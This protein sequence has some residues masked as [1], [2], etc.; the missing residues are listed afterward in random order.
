[1]IFRTKMKR[2][3]EE[4]GAESDVD[5]DFLDRVL[6]NL[7]DFG[8]GAKGKRSKKKHKKRKT[9]NEEEE[10]EDVALEEEA[11]NDETSGV[12]DKADIRHMNSANHNERI[13]KATSSESASQRASSSNVQVVTFQDPLKKSKSKKAVEPEAKPPEVKEKKK[14][15]PDDFLT[16]EKARLEVHRFGI[17]GFQKQQQ[18]VFEQDRAVMLGARPPKKDYVNYKVYQQMVKERK[19]KEKEEMKSVSV[20]RSA[21]KEGKSWKTWKTKVRTFYKLNPINMFNIGGNR[22]CSQRSVYCIARFFN[23]QD[24]HRT[25][26]EQDAAPQE[27]AGSWIGRCSQEAAGSWIGRSPTGGCRLLDRTLLTGGCR[28]PDRTQPAGGCRLPDR[29]QP[30]GGC[31]LPDRTQPTGGCRLLDSTQPTGG[32]RLLDGTQPTGRC[33]LLDRTQPTG[34][35]RLLDSMLPTGRCRLLDR[36]QPTG[37]CRLLDRPQPT[38]G[39]RILDR[40]ILSPAVTLRTEKPKSS[41]SGGG[42]TG[43]VGRFKNGM[44]VLSNK[45]I[46]KLNVK[47]RK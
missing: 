44:L 23:G 46:Q 27:A 42:L 16:I 35:C 33:R 8:D 22:S 19:L 10:E 4:G 21:E 1:D 47:V 9:G 41:S 29:T 12:N 2:K 40:P 6:N 38:G 26:T 24:P 34:G 31:R 18:R 39:C 37:G 3:G 43:Q 5:Q 17:T 7:Y 13:P 20:V 45:D 32:C 28:L 15:D 36:T 30:A 14:K 11:S 25:T